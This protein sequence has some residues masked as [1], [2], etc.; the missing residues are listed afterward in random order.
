MN[1]TSAQKRKIITVLLLVI[2]LLGFTLFKAWWEKKNDDMRGGQSSP[3]ASVT[4]EEVA[5]AKTHLATLTVAPKIEGKYNRSDFGAAWLDVDDNNC[6]TRNDMLQRDLAN[7]VL[8]GKCVVLEGD[9][10]DPYTGKLIHFVK[11][12]GSLVDIDHMVALG[13][14]YASGAG[15]LPLE[16]RKALANDPVNL[17]AV[18]A[19]AN[20]A[21]GDKN[22]A[23]WL[24]PNESFRCAYVVKQITVKEKYGL[25]VTQEEKTVMEKTLNTCATS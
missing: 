15:N 8:E 4:A 17:L 3:A 1:L 18:D 11:G 24:P 13:N 10:Q 2:L 22:A 23:E 5:T 12:H 21:K 20:R 19:P 7:V 9:L 25:S 14:A 16:A 6:D